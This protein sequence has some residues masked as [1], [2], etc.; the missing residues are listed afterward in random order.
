VLVLTRFVVA[1][2]DEA[3][4]RADAA[5]ALA[6]LAERPG[7][8]RGRLARA[9][10]DGA[11]WLLLTEWE[12]VGAYRR[13]PGRSP[14]RARTRSSTAAR[15][16]TA[17]PTPTRPVP[18]ERP[19][20]DRDGRRLSAMTASGRLGAAAAAL[21]LAGGLLSHALDEEGLL[22]GVREAERVREFA[23][24]GAARPLLLLGCLAAG[25]AIGALVA[26]LDGR[27]AG[28]GPRTLLALV[29]AGQAASFASFEVVARVAA[30]RDVAEV[31]LEPG[32]AA[33]VVVQVAIAAA[34]VLLLLLAARVLAVR[35]P[36]D[37]TS[38]A[39]ATSAATAFHARPVPPRRPAG[40][41]RGRAPPCVVS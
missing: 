29:V 38:P 21:V 6:A 1:P 30:G 31:F 14:S 18:V 16:A 19:P 22:P 28:V 13:A 27:R 39:P 15:P 4:F 35:P 34:F 36:R 17:R 9:I 25:A 41:P 3:G 26:R 7:W 23:E 2:A 8:V 33:G 11:A 32:F 10:D 40:R 5:A 24:H 20:A 37:T 12:S